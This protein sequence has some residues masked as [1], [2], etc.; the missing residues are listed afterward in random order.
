M[1]VLSLR[2]H[3]ETRASRASFGERFITWLDRSYE[4]LKSIPLAT[5]SLV[6]ILYIL[7]YSDAATSLLCILAISSSCSEQWLISLSF[8]IQSHRSFAKAKRL[9]S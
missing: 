2:F 5:Y 6:V 8:F 7:Y 9:L 3:S 1:L 4:T